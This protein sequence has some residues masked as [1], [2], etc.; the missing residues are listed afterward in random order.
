MACAVLAF[1]ACASAAPVFAPGLPLRREAGDDGVGPSAAALAALAVL[2]VGVWAAVQYRRRQRGNGRT[3]GAAPMPWLG[4]LF[5]DAQGRELRVLEAA[6]LGSHARLHVVAW[7]GREY[8]VSSALD[9]V[10]VLD[11]RDAPAEDTTDDTGGEA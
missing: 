1:T 6:S 3:R 2:M 11:R 8:L 5:P 10:R 9:Q 4:R 7:R